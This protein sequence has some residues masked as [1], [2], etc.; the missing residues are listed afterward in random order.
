MLAYVLAHEPK[1]IPGTGALGGLGA[2]LLLVG[3]VRAETSLVVPPAACLGVAY[4]IALVVRG[5]RVDG[6]APLVAAGLFLCAELASWSI[7]ERF[8]IPAES[9]IVRARVLALAGLAF[10]SLAIAALAVAIA[11]APAGSGLAWTVLG[12]VS[13]VAVVGLAVRLARKPA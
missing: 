10:A 11:S 13:A 6:A 4:A 9:A 1:A 8:R 3:L 7:D 12:A 2:L 5:A